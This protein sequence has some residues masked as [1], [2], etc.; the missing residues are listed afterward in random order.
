M[1]IGL[2]YERVAEDGFQ[3]L[4]AAGEAEL[5]V[6][7]SGVIEAEDLE[8]LFGEE[9]FGFSEESEVGISEEEVFKVGY[10]V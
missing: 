1:A 9:F 3:N 8:G 4:A 7:F 5:L 10:D 6:E 2:E